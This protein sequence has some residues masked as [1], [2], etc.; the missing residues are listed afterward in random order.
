MDVELTLQKLASL[1]K[2]IAKGSKT[3]EEKADIQKQIDLLMKK[4]N[5]ST[6]EE[7]SS[8]TDPMSQSVSVQSG[9]I[10][11][12]PYEF[13]PL[14]DDEL[15]ANI[16][17]LK[18]T[19]KFLLEIVAKAAGLDNASDLRALAMKLHEDQYFA[20]VIVMRDNMTEFVPL[21]SMEIKKLEEGYLKLPEVVRE[22]NERQIGTSNVTEIVMRSFKENFDQKQGNIPNDKLNKAPSWPMLNID[23]KSKS[24][25]S[26]ESGGEGSWLFGSK[27]ER[28][29]EDGYIE[30]MLPKPTRREGQTPTEADVQ[31]FIEEILDIST[32]TVPSKSAEKA[33]GGFIVRGN[34]RMEDY[35][36]MIETIDKKLAESSLSEKIQ[37]CFI[38]DPTPVT[39]EQ[40]ETGSGRDPVLYV[41][42]RDLTPTANKLVTTLVSLTGLFFVFSLSCAFFTLNDTV[43]DRFQADQ[44]AGFPNDLDWLTPLVT[45]TF[46]SFLAIQFIHEAAHKI[47]AISNGVS[48]LFQI[49]Q[50]KTIF[51]ESIPMSVTIS[52]I[53]HC[54]SLFHLLNWVRL[55]RLHH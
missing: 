7:V 30:N 42:G 54:L 34:P 46:I 33:P 26:T 48:L 21:T 41:C 10:N 14:T 31:Y 50:K 4:L 44:V 38:S 27:P 17:K 6:S 18:T 37:F 29:P 24:V 9:V 53:Q 1:E 28:K 40:M 15:N 19:E 47:Y 12:N 23:D 52:S 2:S 8:G 49:K 35:D 22:M 16:E 5:T 51:N 39:N 36:T 20:D 25:S 45:P 11:E 43:M 13:K 55:V 3:Q 32:F